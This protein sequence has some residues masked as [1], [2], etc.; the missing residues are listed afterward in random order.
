MPAESSYSSQQQ[1]PNLRSSRQSLKALDR[2]NLTLGDVRDV[3]EPYLAVFL[4]TSYQWNPSQIGLILST[5]NIAGILTQ[6]PIGAVVDASHRKRLLIAI[7]SFAI[8]ISY[9]I[10]VHV[11][12]FPAVLVAQ[13]M[14]GVA[15]VTIIPAIS[16]ISLGLVGPDRLER[17]VGRNEAF[18]RAG[19]A[20]TAV[21][22][23]V[24]GQLI[25]LQWIFYLLVLLCLVTILLVFRIRHQEIDNTVARSDQP[26]SANDT[27]QGRARATANDLL[28][29]RPLLIFGLSVFLFYVANA[30]LLPLVAQ[31]LTGG[32][33][34][35]PSA[36]LSACIAVSQFMTI[37]IAAW[38]GTMADRW[39]RKPLLG[40]AFVAVTLRAL[41]YSLTDNPWLI[42][43]IQTLDGVA[44]GIFAV[45]IV[46]VVADLTQGTGRFNLVQGA[47]YTIIG[48]GAAL[49]N[50][51]SGFLVKTAGFSA[52]FFTLASI[53]AIGLIWLWSAMPET[54]AF[55]AAKP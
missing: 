26:S 3:F 48:I 32:Q 5:T 23:G 47:I 18:N 49:S 44:S 4:A 46:V 42:V 31:K 52:G 17:R 53:A 13:A 34:N 40:L 21:F 41:F 6:T 1:Q 30:A 24:L 43:G 20:V 12:A 55:K 28:Q 45:L 39:G 38:S 29:N 51:G 50:L 25:G 15:A 33:S 7:A 10:I 54:K 14:I 9:L 16:A 35:T 8:A 37:P 22:A 27:E 36:F 11:P 19:N 2:L